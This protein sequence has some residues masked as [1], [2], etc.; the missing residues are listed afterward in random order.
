MAAK[1]I[2][3]RLD[4]RLKL[5]SGV[6]EVEA[7][8]F[9]MVRP[10]ERCF[11][12]SP[13]DSLNLGR[14]VRP[15]IFRGRFRT[16]SLVGLPKTDILSHQWQKFACGIVSIVVRISDITASLGGGFPWN[17][18]DSVTLVSV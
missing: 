2:A 5:Q 17:F 6:A 4:Q 8:S 18:V 3:G 1:E 13:N 15:S 12:F 10:A 11:L 14:V 16:I 9:V 7:S